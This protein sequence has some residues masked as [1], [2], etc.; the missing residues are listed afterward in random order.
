MIKI[1]SLIISRVALFCT[2]SS[3]SISFCK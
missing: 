2:F 1:L 3:K